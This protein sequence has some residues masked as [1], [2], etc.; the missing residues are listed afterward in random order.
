MSHQKNNIACVT[1]ASGIIGS[2][3]VERL[4]EAGYR[5]RV[6]TRAR[7]TPAR[8]GI[9]SYCGSLDDKDILEDFLRDA[10]MLFHCAGER[11]DVERMWRVNVEGTRRL[12]DVARQLDIRYLCYISSAGVVGRTNSCWVDETENCNPGNEYEKS[13]W[14]AEKLVAEGLPDCSVVILRPTNVIDE[15]NAGILELAIRASFLDWVKV[16][17]KGSE[18]AH[19]VHAN[20]VA[21]AAI[22]FIPYTFQTP[23]CFFVS[24]DQDERNTVVGL[25]RLF[26]S[27]SRNQQYRRISPE[28]TL[29]VFVPH[30]FRAVLRGKTIRG[31]VRYSSKKISE[32][33]F[34]YETGVEGAVRRVAEKMN[35]ERERAKY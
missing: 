5:V 31:D 30:Y 35:K 15:D 20:D 4:L 6:L 29:P 11:R 34:K 28:F 27:L 33:G 3:I 18:C 8:N 17:V 9:V 22:Y 10:S 13:K 14:M 7:N 1:G 21:A 2:R 24:C 26:R 19:I 12:L 25:W 16:V 23:E 32:Y